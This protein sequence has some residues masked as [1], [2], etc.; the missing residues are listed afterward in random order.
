MKKNLFIIALSLGMVACSSDATTE[1]ATDNEVTETGG[2][3]KVKEMDRLTT[4]R[5]AFYDK[6]IEAL[7]AGKVD[8]ANAFKAQMDSVDA[9]YQELLR[10]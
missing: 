3:D 7:E 5:D 2:G 4:E 1:T 8:E 6:H 9:V 10:K